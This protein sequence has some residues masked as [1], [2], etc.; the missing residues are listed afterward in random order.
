[1]KQFFSVKEAVKSTFTGKRRQNCSVMPVGGGDRPQPGKCITMTIPTFSSINEAEEVDISHYTQD[2]LE[3]LRLEDPFLYYS[4]PAMKR[5]LFENDSSILNSSSSRRS[6]CPTILIN[7]DI[8]GNDGPQ[9][10]QQLRRG[11]VTR[12]RRLSTEPHPALLMQNI[13]NEMNLKENFDDSDTDEEDEKLLEA[14]ANG[15]FDMD[16]SS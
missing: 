15:T 7:S 14:L 13:M 8:S 10:Q 3:R 4:I 6:S 16:D 11:S 1:M 5:S 2:D 12:A 9:Q